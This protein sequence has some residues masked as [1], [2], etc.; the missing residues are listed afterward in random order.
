MNN[1]ERS[2]REPGCKVLRDEG[3]YCESRSGKGAPGQSAALRFRGRRKAPTALRCS[4]TW[5]VAQ[6]TSLTAFAAFKQSRRV[7]HASALARAATRPA[8]LGAPQARR[9]LSGRAFAVAL[10]R[11]ARAEPSRQTV[12]N[13]GDLW[14][15]E[16]RRAGVGARS[17]LRRLT[18]RSCLS[19]VSAANEASS[20]PRPL[21]ENRSAV[22]ALRRPRNH[23]PPPRTAWR[24]AAALRRPARN[25]AGRD[26]QALGSSTDHPHAPNTALRAS[27]ETQRPH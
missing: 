1:V 6:L 26:A 12:P 4:A 14:S 9:E 13:G 24:D 27:R 10:E 2:R 7:R 11:C 21:T 5:P 22:G 20:A 25:T 19:A 17:A 8:L 18:R 16:D 3:R 23:E 15:D